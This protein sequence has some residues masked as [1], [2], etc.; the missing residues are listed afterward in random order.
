MAFRS[1]FLAKSPD[2]ER[3]KHRNV[4]ETGK[5]VLHSVLVRNLEGAVDEYRTLSKKEKIDAIILCPGFTHGEV[6][7]LVKETGGKV[8]IS[9]SRS[10]GP[11]N[12]MIQEVFK[13]ESF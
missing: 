2:A 7:E 11:G 13:R 1:L 9:I 3:E 12:G 8:T 4:I 5:S 10:D 6:A